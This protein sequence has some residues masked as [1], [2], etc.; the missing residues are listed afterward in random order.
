MGQ[1][2]RQRFLAPKNWG[3]ARHMV[4]VN[5]A[6][7]LI[8]TIRQLFKARIVHKSPEGSFSIAPRAQTIW[9]QASPSGSPINWKQ[10]TPQID[11]HSKIKGKVILKY[12][13]GPIINHHFVGFVD[14]CTYF[15]QRSLLS[16]VATSANWHASGNLACGG[17]GFQDSLLVLLRVLRGL[18]LSYHWRSERQARLD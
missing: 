17:K 18:Q 8:L 4:G 9:R 14:C 15:S 10:G 7:S 16:S 1:K 13:T 3:S 6:F 5:V 2:I 12:F 11:E